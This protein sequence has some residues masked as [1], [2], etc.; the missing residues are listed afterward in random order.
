MEIRLL[1]EGDAQALWDLRRTALQSEPEAFAESLEEHLQKPVET[2]AAR[3]RSTS[4]ENFVVGAV[5][6]TA[7]AGMV[8]FYRETHAKRRHRGWIWGMYV[9][10][11]FRG[12]GL[13]RQLLEDLI[14]RAGRIEGLHRLLLTV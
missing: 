2:V 3:L 8:G 7:L 12:T 6:E 4:D 10:T 14:H 9:A 5:S 13:G 11:E 1:R